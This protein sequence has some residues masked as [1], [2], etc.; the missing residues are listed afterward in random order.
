MAFLNISISAYRQLSLLLYF[1]TYSTTA[2]YVRNTLYMNSIAEKIVQA[3]QKNNNKP[4]NK[5]LLNQKN[6][7]D[8]NEFLLILKPE[9]FANTS[10]DEQLTIINTILEKLLAFN[11][12]IS[13]VRLLNATYLNQ[14]KIIDQH[15]GMINAA[16]RDIHKNITEEALTNFQRMYEI[17]FHEAPVWGALEAIE[18]HILSEEELNLLWKDC[19]IDRLA[20]G[21][22]CS[23][24]NHKGQTLYIVNGFHPPQL[25]HFIDHNRI[26]VT[27]NVSSPVNWKLARQEMTGNTYPEKASANSIRGMLYRQFGKFGFDDAAYV[28]NSIHLS[29]G[30]LEG[31]IELRRFNTDFES[32]IVPA[33]EEYAF[34][35]LLKA[36]FN[37]AQIDHILSNPTVIFEGKSTNL[38][39]LTEETNNNEAIDK[40]KQVIK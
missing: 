25:N 31:L 28:L 1:E 38:F 16:A 19:K 12:G 3:I 13:N 30:P 21:Q 37:Q 29:A 2:C 15:Y 8:N 24:L 6:K 34:G 18:K 22:Y 11:F 36:N 7:N 10:P 32:N 23:R 9:V 39:D 33:I 20:G 26:T 4:E 17:S 40:L 14:Y 5:E 27:M 35:R